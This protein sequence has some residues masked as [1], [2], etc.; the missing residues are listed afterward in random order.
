MAAALLPIAPFPAQAPRESNAD[1]GRRALLYL[2]SNDSLTAALDDT[3]L[4][5]AAH[6]ISFAVTAKDISVP[7]V[8]KLADLQAQL[9]TCLRW[10]AQDAAAQAAQLEADAAAQ[11][12][13]QD[14]PA[15][16][17]QGD[18][19]SLVPRQPGPIAPAPPAMLV[20]PAP[21]APAYDFDPF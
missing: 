8:D 18:G 10:R 2:L 14:A 6:A 15:P 13:A 4:E 5:A 17:A 7:A 16:P 20:P 21:L 3:A 9:R 19:G 12:P 1:Y 11:A